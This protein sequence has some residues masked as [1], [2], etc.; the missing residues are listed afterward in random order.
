[1]PD[2]IHG[3]A[4]HKLSKRFSLDR[5]SLYMPTFHLQMPLFSHRTQLHVGAFPVVHSALALP[6]V[7]GGSWAILPWLP[8]TRFVDTYGLQVRYGGVCPQRRPAARENRFLLVQGVMISVGDP[9]FAK[10]IGIANWLPYFGNVEVGHVLL[11][12]GYEWPM[13]SSC[14]YIGSSRVQGVSKSESCRCTTTGKE[15]VMTQSTKTALWE[16]K[17]HLLR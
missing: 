4:S 15:T 8:S 2:V 14:S 1:M 3:Y 6:L 7:S 9:L 13:P 11:I 17:T 10:G 16:N 12:V 5:G